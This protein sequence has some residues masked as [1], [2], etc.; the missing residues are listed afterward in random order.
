MLH[1]GPSFPYETLKMI[2]I[3]LQTEQVTKYIPGS[4]EMR[5]PSMSVGH[6]S[7]LS[8]SLVVLEWITHFIRRRI[9]AEPD[10]SVYPKYQI[11]GRQLWD[12]LILFHNLLCQALDKSRPVVP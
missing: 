8:R 4:R 5:L 6:S 3:S 2:R 9:R 7:P 11:F 12:R 10:V 1:T